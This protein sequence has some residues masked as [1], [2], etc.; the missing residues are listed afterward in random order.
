MSVAVQKWCC[1]ALS[2]LECAD[3]VYSELSSIFLCNERQTYVT[4]FIW[5]LAFLWQF[6]N[7]H[8]F[9]ELCMQIMPLEVTPNF[10]ILI[11][12]H[13]CSDLA[14]LRIT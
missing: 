9:V 12:S 5:L 13:Y 4:L 14:D 8:I 3:K 1:I 6:Y 7:Q 2:G 10:F 11:S